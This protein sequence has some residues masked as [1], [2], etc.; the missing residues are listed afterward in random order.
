MTFAK[1]NTHHL[2]KKRKGRERER[3]KDTEREK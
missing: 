3:E 2:N 1:H